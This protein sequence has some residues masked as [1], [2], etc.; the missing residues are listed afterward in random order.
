MVPVKGTNL[1]MDKA[2]H[3]VVEAGPERGREISVSKDGVRIG[4]SSRNDVVLDDASM[5]R[6]HCRLFFKPDE[7]LWV[8]DL[9]S[10]NETMVNGAAIQE[11]RV[12]PGD[13]ISIGDT[14]IK[15]RSD[16]ESGEV[17]ADA[18]ASAAAAAPVG[19]V[20]PE[21]A[22]DLGLLK[23]SA[24]GVTMPRMRRFLIG[25][26]G[27]MVLIALASW[28]PWARVMQ[29]IDAHRHPPPPPAAPADLPI[30]E[31]TYEHVEATS[32]N[33]F[34][35]FMQLEHGT[36]VVQ[37]DDLLNARHVRR[38]KKVEADLMRDL[39]KSVESSGFMDLLEDYS[40]L[41]PGVYEL[42]DLDV[43][44]GPK[45]HRTRV[46]NH[47]EPEPFAT[48]RSQIE[49]FGKNELGLAALAMEPEK[50]IEKAKE[51][52]LLGKKLYDEREVRYENLASAIRAFKEA[53]LYLETI[54]P[55]PDFYGEALSR[56]TDCEHELQKRYDDIRFM[57][58]RAVKLQDWK[59]AERQL[60]IVIEMI[61]D[62]SDERNRVANKTLVDVGRH[63]GAEK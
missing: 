63:L 1:G 60:R 25:I 51:T 43:T 9:G 26:V 33:I 19:R 49:E 12:K 54:E 56:R 34:R 20:A 15:V 44:I 57:A 40:G 41:A 5:S 21:P 58:E 27:V 36:L 18:G 10:S 55:K 59:E 42:S 32:S 14:V 38:E 28:V 4:R 31:L 6:F 2:I 61:P 7:G 50:L 62:R 29:A 47:V 16:R 45:A 11:A 24:T 3:L 17:T 46:L 13:T 35:Y 22:I 48:V 8:A 37:V 30:M 39:A 52:V 53:E 23:K